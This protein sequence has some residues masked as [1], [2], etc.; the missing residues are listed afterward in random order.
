MGRKQLILKP[1]PNGK[2]VC[3]CRASRIP[4]CI[5]EEVVKAILDADCL[6]DFLFLIKVEDFKQ[7]E[8]L[9]GNI[10][11][12]L[13]RNNPN[14]AYF[15]ASRTSDGNYEISYTNTNDD[16]VRIDLSDLLKDSNYNAWEV[17]GDYYNDLTPYMGAIAYDGRELSES[18][19]HQWFR[20][21][22]VDGRAVFFKG[23]F[24]GLSL[25]SITYNPNGADLST[26]AEAPIF[27]FRA[28]K[29]F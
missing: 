26:D 16:E 1:G 13:D 29:S 9:V 22:T 19:S 10:G 2:G 21:L 6:S 23:M 8:L 28:T 20:T 24:A 14:T 15:I 4:K 27:D 17:D 12:A 25:E 7:I 5:P 3:L 11:Y 18:N